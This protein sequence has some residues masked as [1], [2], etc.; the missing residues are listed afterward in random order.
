VIARDS[1]KLIPPHCADQASIAINHRQSLLA[2]VDFR[3]PLSGNELEEINFGCR[4]SEDSR[5][6]PPELTLVCRVFSETAIKSASS[7]LIARLPP[8][9]TTVAGDAA[10][11]EFDVPGQGD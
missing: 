1:N 11:M 2:S 6:A 8:R 4:P 10:R 7:D 9:A 5:D 3:C